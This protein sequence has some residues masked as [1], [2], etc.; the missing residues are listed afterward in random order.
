MDTVPQLLQRAAMEVRERAASAASV[1]LEPDE[2]D[3]LSD[4]LLPAAR[5]PA[6]PATTALRVLARLF[7]D[8]RAAWQAVSPA[9][10]E[11]MDTVRRSG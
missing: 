2:H 5:G 7:G 11:L 3:L 1:G 9:F 10:V 4:R 6:A 8:E